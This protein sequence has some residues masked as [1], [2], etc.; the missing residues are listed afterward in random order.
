MKLSRVER[1]VLNKYYSK[2]FNLCVLTGFIHFHTY[3]FTVGTKT[4]REVEFYFNRKHPFILFILI[5]YLPRLIFIPLLG[6]FW[7]WYSITELPGQG[8]PAKDRIVMSRGKIKRKLRALRREYMKEHPE[9]FDGTIDDPNVGGTRRAGKKHKRISS[10]T[11]IWSEEDWEAYYERK[12]GYGGGGY[13]GKTYDPS[14]YTGQLDFKPRTDVKVYDGSIDTSVDDEIPE[15]EIRFDNLYTALNNGYIKSVERFFKKKYNIYPTDFGYALERINRDDTRIYL[16]VDCDYVKIWEG[17]NKA[18]V[19]K[20]LIREAEQGLIQR[21][22]RELLIDIME[23][24][25]IDITKVPEEKKDLL[26]KQYKV[27]CVPE[28]DLGLKKAKK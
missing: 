9:E 5:L 16:D 3:V 4:T 7:Y 22:T 19:L 18:E 27:C 1:L 6:I 2:F 24:Y 25:N 17:E 26:Q 23:K 15:D 8:D 11:Q 12:Y 28:E 21:T 14:N 10:Q 20:S 13:S